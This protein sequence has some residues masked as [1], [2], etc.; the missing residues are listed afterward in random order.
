MK[1]EFNTIRMIKTLSDYIS[2][3]KDYNIE[4]TNSVVYDLILYYCNLIIMER[5][6]C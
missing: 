2:Y 1:L 4:Y 3:N 5:K 6:M